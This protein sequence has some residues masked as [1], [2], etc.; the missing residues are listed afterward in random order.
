MELASTA[1]AKLLHECGILRDRLQ[2][3]S[4]NFLVE[5]E[6]K[7]NPSPT[8]ESDPK[9]KS[10]PFVTSI[11]SPKSVGKERCPVSGGT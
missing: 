11:G 8:V 2:E 10:G 6:D 5:E 1:N 9:P 3:C 4:V 7:L